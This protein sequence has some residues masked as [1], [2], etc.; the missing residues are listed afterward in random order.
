MNKSTIIILSFFFTILASC[1]K[2]D[3][4]DTWVGGY[5]YTTNRDGGM[6]GSMY[7]NKL[8]DDAIMLSIDGINESM[9]LKVGSDGTLTAVVDSWWCS[10]LNGSITGDK[11]RFEYNI[12]TEPK[13]KVCYRGVKTGETTMALSDYR[14]VWTGIYS[15][16]RNDGNS[17][18]T[19]TLKK[20]SYGR[21][22]LLFD[23]DHEL[24]SYLFDVDNNGNITQVDNGS[25]FR[26]NAT[27]TIAGD[28]LQ[29]SYTTTTAGGEIVTSYYC[30]K[31]DAKGKMLSK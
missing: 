15:W 22:G 2:A 31:Q 10:E 13:T 11:I 18:G 20:V 7:V 27:G 3:Y 30:I 23:C 14:D 25:S 12:M 21:L 8:G 17:S 4:R 28:S 6:E 29:F 9:P 16:S 1:S 26:S 24:W 19:L 5:A